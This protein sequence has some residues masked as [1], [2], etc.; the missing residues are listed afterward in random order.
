[1]QVELRL[2]GIGL[3]D[4]HHYRRKNFHFL[5]DSMFVMGYIIGMERDYSFRFRWSVYCYYRLSY[6]RTGLSGCSYYP[7]SS[8]HP[9]NRGSTYVFQTQYK[10]PSRYR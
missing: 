3:Y 4:A 10:H 8:F 5:F 1:M 9:N 7:S 2:L 6:F